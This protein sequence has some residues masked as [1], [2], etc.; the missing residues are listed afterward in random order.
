MTTIVKTVDRTVSTNLAFGPELPGQTG[1]FWIGTMTRRD[2]TGADRAP[3]TYPA[4]RKVQR[5]YWTKRQFRTE[6][7][8]N[9]LYQMMSRQPGVKKSTLRKIP[10]VLRRKLVIRE[11]VLKYRVLWE[12]DERYT[13]EAEH[14]Y[15]GTRYTLNSSAGM[16]MRKTWVSTGVSLGTAKDLVA[17]F[18]YVSDPWSSSDSI[19][20][21]G[22]LREKIAGSGFNAAI[23]LGE[24]PRALKMIAESA[25]KVY[26]AVK[27]LKRGN[28]MGAAKALTGKLPPKS[29]ARKLKTNKDAAAQNWLELQYGW[30]PLVQDVYDAAVFVDHQFRRPIVNTYRVVR[31]ARGRKLHSGTVPWPDAYGLRAWNPVNVTSRRSIIARL[32]EKSVARLAGLIDPASLAW[33]L[34][35]WS[36]VVDWFIPVGNYL[37]ARGLANSVTGSYVTTHV[38][39]VQSKGAKAIMTGGWTAFA[40][41]DGSK[42]SVEWT[43]INRTIS[44]SLSVPVPDFKPLSKVA[45]WGH[46]A[47]AVALLVGVNKG[48]SFV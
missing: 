24:A 15:S 29:V 14:A 42:C 28:P 9:P 33:E 11:P 26:T 47:N 16:V 3:G 34:L 39:K 45:S 43:R 30:K 48:K 6:K 19:S 37:S 1:P 8:P 40:N 4:M 10:K 20:L 44:T 31:F 38:L 36:F 13:Y 46:A 25:T 32:S 35:P 21:L 2:T 7:Y 27:Q 23:C 17:N 22:N 12:R 18:P 41:H 5:P